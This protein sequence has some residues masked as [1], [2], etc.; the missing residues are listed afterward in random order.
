MHSL[1]L[2]LDRMKSELTNEEKRPVNWDSIFP[3]VYF[4][5]KC[6]NFTSIRD[7]GGFISREE[8]FE[9]QNACMKYLEF[10]QSNDEIDQA[11]HWVN[12]SRSNSR[13]NLLQRA[14]RPCFV[15]LMKN[16]RNNLIKIGMTRSKP[17]FR[18]KTLC[19]EEPEI[20][21][22]FYF[23]GTDED[24]LLLHAEFSKHRIRGEWFNL[25]DDQVNLIKTRFGGRIIY[26]DWNSLATSKN[27][28]R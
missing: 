25:N 15:Y 11:N 13:R 26:P 1:R 24:E 19:S 28:L 17:Q 4:F 20:L 23:K 5:R 2:A 22:L 10:F 12:A 6:G 3:D 16:G 9:I 14:K 27:P 7:Q 8:V 18:E 21:T